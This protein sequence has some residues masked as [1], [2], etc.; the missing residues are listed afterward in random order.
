MAPGVYVCMYVCLCVD[1]QSQPPCLGCVDRP[2]QTPLATASTPQP[3]QTIN[4]PTP[5][6]HKNF[7][8]R[9]CFVFKFHP[10]FTAYHWT[11]KND[12]FMLSNA[13]HLA[14]G[15]GGSFAFQVCVCV[16]VVLVIGWLRGIV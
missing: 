9:E 10:E 1:W 16:G 12:Y 7:P 5:T 14:M 15:G 2:A 3:P 8:H 4:P 11:G 6:P 13:Q